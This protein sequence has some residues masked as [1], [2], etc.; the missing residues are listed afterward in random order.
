MMMFMEHI[1]QYYYSIISHLHFLTAFQSFSRLIARSS[2][3]SGLGS[4][5]HTSRVSR[6]QFPLSF[7]I[8]K[9]ER[10]DCGG[11][12]VKAENPLESTP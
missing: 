2:L 3:S 5:I 12:C 4:A 9:R 10:E 11:P 6:V 7:Q 1:E 8:P